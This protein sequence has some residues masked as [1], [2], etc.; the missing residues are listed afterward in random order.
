MDIDRGGW[1]GSI[2]SCNGFDPFLAYCIGGRLYKL[3]VLK[4]APFHHP[5][6]MI[7]GSLTTECLGQMTGEFVEP[8]ET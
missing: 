3:R 7:R 1:D 2:Q 5:N 8:I 4:S 6:Q